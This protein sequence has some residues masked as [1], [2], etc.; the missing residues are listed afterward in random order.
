[1]HNSYHIMWLYTRTP[2]CPET[3]FWYFKIIELIETNNLSYH[4]I[5]LFL[6][7]CRKHEWNINC[8]DERHSLRYLKYRLRQNI[9]CTKTS[10]A[11][12]HRLHQIIDFT[13]ISTAPNHQLHQ[14][15]TSPKHRLHIKHWACW[16]RLGQRAR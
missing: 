11:P 1:M 4:K 9:D 7:S 14:T 5:K 2:V 3:L 15:S 6:T 13:K 16:N 8:D 10:T 12:K